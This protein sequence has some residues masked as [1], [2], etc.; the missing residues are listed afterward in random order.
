MM[1]YIVL[2]LEKY[3]LLESLL[4]KRIRDRTDT[5]MVLKRKWKECQKRKK[6]N[7]NEISHLRVVIISYVLVRRASAII[8]FKKMQRLSLLVVFQLA[9]IQ[10]KAQ[11]FSIK[12]TRRPFVRSRIDLASSVS[13]R[14][15]FLAVTSDWINNEMKKQSKLV[16]IAKF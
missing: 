1:Q 4:S 5:A 8:K 3:H 16:A 10:F 13:S 7:K 9:I 11:I 2:V 14:E 12:I 15:V 6:I